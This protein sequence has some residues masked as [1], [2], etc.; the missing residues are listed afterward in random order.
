MTDQRLRARTI[1]YTLPLA[2][3]IVLVAFSYLFSSVF[4]TGNQ[5][6]D[7]IDFQISSFHWIDPKTDVNAASRELAARY[8]I[9]AAYLLVLV[10]SLTGG[11]YSGALCFSLRKRLKVQHFVIIPVLVATSFIVSYVAFVSSWDPFWS[12]SLTGKL[13]L[14]ASTH[15]KFAMFDQLSTWTAEATIASLCLSGAAM[16]ALIAAEPRNPEELKG[17]V[18]SQALLLYV[19][20]ILLAVYAVSAACELLWAASLLPQNGSKEAYYV[21][22]LAVAAALAS[23]IHNTLTIAGI[24][25]PG[26]FVFSQQ[27]M[28]LA[29]NQLPTASLEERLDF[30]GKHGLSASPYE[31]ATK[32]IAV[33]SPLIAGFPLAHLLTYFF[34]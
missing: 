14:A 11:L 20:A 17:K 12:L 5:T 21:I 33:L 16:S 32:T 1:E 9:E 30:L 18:S 10:A 27:A 34:T 8:L 3:F 6:K 19:N 15:A 7:V 24:H 31:T 25:G 26:F 28:E 13:T 4:Q 29:D 23:G 22:R 2:S